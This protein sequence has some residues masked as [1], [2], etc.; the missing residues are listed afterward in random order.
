MKTIIEKHDGKKPRA[1]L[2]L[3]PK[4]A[5]KQKLK[6]SGIDVKSIRNKLPK[7][8]R[9]NITNMKTI[10]EKHGGNKQ[11]A[12]LVLAPKCAQKQ[13]LKPVGIDVKSIRNKLPKYSRSNNTI[14]NTTIEKHDGKKPRA[15][16]V[17]APKCAQKQKLKL[18]G[19]DVKSI[20]NKLPKYS[21]SNITNMKTIIEKHDGNKQRAVLVL[22]PKCAQKQKLKPVGIDVKSIRNKLPKY[23]R[24]NNTIMN[25][26]IEKHDGNKQRAVLVLAPKCAQKQ[27]LKPVG[28]D[29]KSIRNKLPK[30]SRSNN[31]IMNTTIEKH[32]GKKPRAVLVLAPKCAQKQKLKLS[33]IDVKSIRN[34]LP[35]YSR[36]NN[37]I[38]K[39]ITEKHDGKNRVLFLF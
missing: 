17:L 25:T 7:Y 30:Y 11:R 23:S 29:V 12:V 4:C 20:R 15:L 18:S 22:A 9:S 16:L 32:D 26:I 28:I 31:T 14:M 10:I 33:G 27:K 3:A 2:V 19:L 39:T 38:M 6:L 5:Q 21:R 24:S 1:V 13:K 36:S 37:T 8:S 34:N 35:K